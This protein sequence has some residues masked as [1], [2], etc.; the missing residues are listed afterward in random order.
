MNDAF[1]RFKLGDLECVS[2]S[3][4][5]MDYPLKNFFRNVPLAQVEAA[6]RERGQPVDYIR[7][8]YTFLYVDTG[9]HHA[10]VD[11]GLGNLSPHTGRLVGNMRAVGIDPLAIDTVLITHAHGDHIGGA[12]DGEGNPVYAN[13]RYY[14][15]KGEWDFWTSEA[16]LVKAPELHVRVAREKL[17]ALQERM[18]LVER[19]GEVLPGIGVLPAPGHTP[20]HMV[21]TI[22]SAGKQLW[23]TG[24][25]VLHPLHLEHPDWLPIYDILSEQAA[26]SKQRIFD[27]AAEQGVLVLGQH[28]HPFP[29]LGYVSREGEGW[30]WRPI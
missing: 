13:A 10:L 8:P 28:F 2:L 9:A 3:D 22:S 20:G 30:R 24:D 5:S 12:L 6:L 11:M 18:T 17:G 4:G 26:A 25:V 19:E 21:V 29:S 16:A 1:Y 7:T 15:W 14:L 27:R 23:Y